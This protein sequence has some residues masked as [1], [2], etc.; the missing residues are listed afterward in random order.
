M[1]KKWT[2]YLIQHSHTDIGYTDRQEKIERY[3]VDYIKS[4]I[5]ILDAARNGSKK[6]WEGYKWTCENFWQVENFLEN[7]NEEFKRKFTKYVKAG[8][9]DISLT[10][11]NMTELVDNEILDQKFQKG[12]DYAETNQLDLNSA[13]TADI[14]GF[15]W[16]YAETLHK[17]GIVNLFSCLHT[18][19]GMFPLYKKQQPFWW[20]TPK[21]NKVLVWNGD[22]YQIGNDFMLIPNSYRIDQGAV[23]VTKPDQ[24][25]IAEER[26]FSYIE[27]LEAEN[28]PFDFIPNMISGIVTDNAPPNPRLIESIYQWNEKHGEQV[29]IALI[30]LNEFFRI[31]RNKDLEIPTYSG[32]WTDWWAD[33]VGST[34]AP[35]K[36]Y[37]DA[38]RKYHLSKKL[39]PKSELGKQSFL[40]EAENQLMMYAEHTWGY[41]SSVS[42]PWNTL[43]NDLDYRKAAYAISANRLIS[44]NLDEVLSNLGEVSQ[45]TD[46]EKYFKVV[47]PHENRVTDYTSVQIKHWEHIDG[48]YLAWDRENYVEVVDC[49]TNEVLDCQLTSIPSGDLIEFA[50]TLDPKEERIVKLRRGK[51]PKQ[52]MIVNHAH[53]GTDRVED[54]ASYPG[55]EEIANT[56]MIETN[57]YKITFNDTSGI[58][59]FVEKQSGRELIH[60]DAPYAPFAGV[61]EK[62]PI[63]TDACTE[64]R[65]MGRNRKGRLTERHP[66]SLKNIKILK[67]GPLFISV[68]MDFELAGTEMYTVFLKIYKHVPKINV[69]VRIQKQNEWAPENLYI[70]L[71]FSLGEAS[72]LF[73]EK[74]GTVFRPAIDQLPGTNTEFY[75]LQNGLAFKDEDQALLVAIKD[76]PLMTLG[77]LDHHKIELCNG[78]THKKNKDLVYSWVMNNY[79]ETNFKVDLSGFYEFDYQLYF[80]SEKQSAEQLIEK[81][82]ELNE[83]LVAFPVNPE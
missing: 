71:P 48:T 25:D 80:V 3:H 36:I 32:D 1:K 8:L 5:D 2:L 52:K 17:N 61:Y 10:Y 69:N 74:T 38:Q 39:D 81:C 14:N 46:R 35:T 68:K 64:R 24:M 29:E 15:S 57:A 27:D 53:I 56:H 12:R 51:A 55:Y 37:R 21:G 33:G 22:H 30:T 82:Q 41:A 4:V 63:Q 58:E 83:G 43:V 45:Q 60:P 75:L 34:P 31:L 78:N 42:E 44:K 13:M 9:I 59:S 19:H 76:T 28:Y 47:N 66:A 6:E 62:T 79:W 50:I 7:S 73:V 18:H 77:T 23:V 40:Q 70:P 54:L 65:L 26:I 16:G 67:D 72:E 49:K 20:E 11:L